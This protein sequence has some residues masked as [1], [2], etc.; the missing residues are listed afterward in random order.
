MKIVKSAVVGLLFVLG[1]ALLIP[2][3]ALIAVM[4]APPAAVG[5]ALGWDP[6]SFLKSP[7][8][9][10]LLAL[11]FTAGFLWECRLLSH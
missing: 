8:G 7:T 5:T 3:L 4:M 9:W 10:A 11:I 2:I 1:S 6:V